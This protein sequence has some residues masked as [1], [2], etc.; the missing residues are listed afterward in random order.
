MSKP[1]LKYFKSYALLAVV[2]PLAVYCLTINL[3]GGQG[4][5]VA[6]QSSIVQNH[7]LAIPLNGTDIVQHGGQNYLVFAPGLAF[8]SLPFGELGFILDNSNSWFPAFAYLMDQLLLAIAASLSSLLV[9]KISLFYTRSRSAALLTA[10]TLVF[11]TSVWP[12]SVE[13]FPHTLSMFLTLSSVYL[14]LLFC[15]VPG[16]PVGLLGVAGFSLGLA[17]FVEYAAAVFA[18][19]LLIYLLVITRDTNRSIFSNYVNWRTIS[20]SVP[21]VATSLGLNGVYNYAIFGDPLRFPQEAYVNGLHF[22]LTD[23]AA[24]VLFYLVSPYRGILFYSPIL[25]LGFYGLYRM[26]TSRSSRADAVLFLSLFCLILVFYSSW[27]TWDG[28]NSYGPR[29]LILGLPFLVIPISI[30]LSE[31]RSI[32]WRSVFLALFVASSLIEGIGTISNALA[33][34]SQNVF[35]YLPVTYS[36]PLI[37]HGKFSVWW[38]QWF[39]LSGLQTVDILLGTIFAF[40][41]FVAAR[42]SLGKSSRRPRKISTSSESPVRGLAQS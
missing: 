24:H 37:V 29:F 7:T 42:L 4:G 33:P 11:A 5:F 8:I 3:D 27:Q 12:F 15:K 30:F 36:I 38:T 31:K 16:K 10:L 41:W 9:Y 20:L 39:G 26:W 14:I 28:G 21:F 6:L 32:V 25:V 34:A 19:P 18:I 22:Y 2:I 35:T 1:P 13:I 40:I 23:L 17:T